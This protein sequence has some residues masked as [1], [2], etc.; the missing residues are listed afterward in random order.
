MNGFTL[1]EAIVVSVILLILSAIAIPLYNGYIKQSKR[2][3]VHDLAITASAAANA[4]F[5]KTGSPPPD[6]S[7]LNL[8]LDNNS[9]IGIEIDSNEIIISDTS[10]AEWVSET[11]YAW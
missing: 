10:D 3:R 1:V 11:L 7:S 6:A 4:Y 8:F 5:R 9:K 2:D